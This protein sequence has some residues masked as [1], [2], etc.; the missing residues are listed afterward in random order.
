MYFGNIHLNNSGR[1]FAIKN[2]PG[3]KTLQ[4]IRGK[5]KFCSILISLC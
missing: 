3:A 2:S 5:H 1:N 4:G